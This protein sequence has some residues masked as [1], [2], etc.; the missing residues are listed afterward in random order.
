MDAIN[1]AVHDTTGFSPI[2]LWEGDASIRKIAMERTKAWRAKKNGKLKSRYLYP[3]QFEVGMK[4]LV[5][6]QDPNS[7]DK[8]R[9]LW[10]LPF[11]ITERIS[12]S[13]W[14]AEPDQPEKPKPGRR[15]VWI[16]HHDQ[17]QPY[18]GGMGIEDIEEEEEV[19]EED[20][21]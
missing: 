10:K 18:L 19:E 17:M 7:K 20:P 9:P 13:M 1:E 8:F 6:D 5:R 4:I 2:E 15:P 11:T 16:F 14:R 21:V 12:R 3:F